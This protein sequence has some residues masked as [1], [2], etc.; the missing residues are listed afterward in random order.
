MTEETAVA[1]REPRSVLI[2]MAERYGMEPSA[3]EATLRGTVCKGTISREEF[4]AFLLVAK[5]Y[6]L[7]PLTKEIYAF[8]AKGGGI[9][10]IVSVDGW[11]RI[12]NEQ[13]TMDGIDF[14]DHF[15]D[16]KLMAITCR[17]YRKDRSV[18]TTVTEYMSECQNTKDTWSKWP[19][20]M[21]RHKALIQ[22][23]RYAFG[24]SGIVDQDE[25]ER[26]TEAPVPQTSGIAARLHGPSEQGF[27]P[28]NVEVLD[29]EIA[30]I[31]ADDE[32]NVE[33]TPEGIA[34][35]DG[36]IFD[37]VAWAGELRL[38]LDGYTDIDALREAWAAHKAELKELSPALFKA[39]NKA[40]AERA[41]AIA[42]VTKD[43]DS[44]L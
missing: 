22:C 33:L 12:I 36:P 11:S 39:L 19:A 44:D 34:A 42:S 40:V 29:A 15:S 10:P 7:N 43:G 35:L 38:A 9:Q 26:A 41:T 23:A 27:S 30:V 8:A 17:I 14:E 6:R 1:V 4:A 37:P 20:R 24:F 2:D 28:S 25:Y 32:I 5:E 21:L 13:P 3:F 16:G 31:E 18:P